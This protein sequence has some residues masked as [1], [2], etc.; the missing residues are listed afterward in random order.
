MKKILVI[1]DQYFVTTS[2]KR[3]L[4]HYDYFVLTANNGFEGLKI[5][6]NTIPDLIIVDLNMPIMDGFEAI[7]EIKKQIQ[8]R[9]IPIIV[10]T[11]F[12][13]TNKVIKLNKLG[14]T[15]YIVKPF[16]QSNLIR[17]IKKAL[18]E[19]YMGINKKREIVKNEPLEA[20][21]P[22]TVINQNT[23]MGAAII[24]QEIPL[25]DAREGMILLNNI[26]LNNMTLYPTGTVLTVKIISKLKELGFS[27]IKIKTD[28]IKNKE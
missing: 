6:R 10:L 3:L 2:L 7:S 8:L 24:G 18:N 27:H 26:K 28:E 21:K 17:R 9:H 4:S 15:D 13:D 20:N 12:S 1:D 16:D 19:D 5:L 22:Y 14:V 25:T 23:K 11:A